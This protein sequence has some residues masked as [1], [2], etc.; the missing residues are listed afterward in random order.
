MV[1]KNPLTLTD[2]L[3]DAVS[4][5]ITTAC[6][7]ECAYCDRKRGSGATLHW[8]QFLTLRERLKT[9][10]NLK[11]IT[12]CGIGEAPLHKDFYRMIEEFSAYKVSL[13]TSG[14]LLLDFE[15]LAALRHIDLLIFSIDA[16]DSEMVKL[17]CGER[18]DYD[19]LLKNLAHTRDFILQSRRQ[20]RAFNAIV[21]CTVNETNLRELP[22]LIDLAAKYKFTAVHYSLPWARES[23][24]EANVDTLQEQFAEVA[25]R[26]AKYGVFVDD[27]FKSYCCIAFTSIMPY[28]NIKGE[29]HPCGYALNQNYGVG[30]ILNEDFAAMWDSERY[31]SFRSGELCRS[32]WMMRME[33]FRKGGT[34]HVG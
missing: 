6:P 27:P 18:F 21:N 9:I 29:V 20:G 4:I 22:K 24:I 8:D 13:I 26:A 33:K 12:F 7:L 19:T 5:E 30:N 32:C 3:P 10:P 15:R 31:H 34:L 25:E 23:F 1:P 28:V 16:T 11:R 17:I 2:K 14:T